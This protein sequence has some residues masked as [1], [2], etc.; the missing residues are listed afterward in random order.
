M[1]ETVRDDVERAAPGRLL[2]FFLVHT[3]FFLSS[4][5]WLRMNA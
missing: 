4:A 3:P 5:R 2:C 1:T